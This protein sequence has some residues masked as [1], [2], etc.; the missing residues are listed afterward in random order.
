MKKNL[1]QLCVAA[2]LPVMLLAGGC[3]ISEITEEKGKAWAEQNGY[4]KEVKYP[5]VGTYNFEYVV[6]GDDG[7]ETD[8][9]FNSCSVLNGLPSN[10]VVNEIK[11]ACE[12]K[13][14]TRIEITEDGKLKVIEPNETVIWKY[15]V[16]EKG[17]LWVSPLETNVQNSAIEDAY[18]NLSVYKLS[19]GRIYLKNLTLSSGAKVTGSYKK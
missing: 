13:A 10:E 15:L 12:E 9:R 14:L 4:V 7:E 18:Y 17:E 19:D 6:V 3:S 5:V 11:T 1:K 8:W 16:D 2:V